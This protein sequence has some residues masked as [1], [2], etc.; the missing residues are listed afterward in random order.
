MEGGTG[1]RHLISSLVMQTWAEVA[2]AP[3]DRT[4]RISP[5]GVVLSLMC[6]LPL[7]RAKHLSWA[8]SGKAVATFSPGGECYVHGTTGCWDT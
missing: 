1:K 6:R 7:A 2:V 5:G 3:L 4:V 8:V